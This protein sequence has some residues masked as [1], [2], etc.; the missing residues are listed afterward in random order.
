MNKISPE[1]IEVL[2]QMRQRMTSESWVN[3]NATAEE[4]AQGKWCLNNHFC[5][6][7]RGSKLFDITYIEIR[8]LFCE[9]ICL[10]KGHGYT[11]ETWAPLYSWNDSSDYQTVSDTLDKVI[12][13][14]IRS[15]RT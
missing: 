12:E 8:D 10:N 1:T 6:T 13:L 2:L 7:V 5:K 11:Y 14:A 4:V 3:H 9:V 15:Q